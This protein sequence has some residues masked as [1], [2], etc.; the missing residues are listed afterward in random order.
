ML[1]R[2]KE[3]IQT[4]RSPRP[5][6]IPPRDDSIMGVIARRTKGTT[7]QSLFLFLLRHDE[8]ASRFTLA[9]TK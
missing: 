7:W 3:I 9:M 8:I 5:P 1:S 4:L 6:F 2:P